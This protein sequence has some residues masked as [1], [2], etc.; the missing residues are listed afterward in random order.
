MNIGILKDKLYEDMS[1][2]YIIEDVVRNYM[3]CAEEAINIP[4]YY[5]IFAK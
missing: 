4:Y 1:N 5:N 3:V 2:I